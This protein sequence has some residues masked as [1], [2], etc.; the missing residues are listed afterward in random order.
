M[1]QIDIMSRIPL[2]EQ[3]IKQVESFIMVG[4]LTKDEQLPSV[5]NLSM[6]LSVNPNTIQK[7]Y[8]ELDRRGIIYSVPGRGNFISQKASSI[9]G[10]S[11]MNRL[12][13]L[14]ILL[15]E[16]AFAGVAKEE[17]LEYV[18]LAYKEEGEDNY[19]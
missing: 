14:E 4:I 19:D 11:K 1:F 15:K 5:R 3:V 16:L 18:E 17:I 9:L 12:P 2:Y 13:E 7:A 8:T 6:E 10:D